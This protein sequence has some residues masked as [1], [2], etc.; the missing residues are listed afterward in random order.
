MTYASEQQA[1][2][3]RATCRGDSDRSLMSSDSFSIKSMEAEKRHLEE[4]ETLRIAGEAQEEEILQYALERS[5]ADLNGEEKGSNLH[6]HG[7]HLEE[8]EDVAVPR[9]LE[10]YLRPTSLRNMAPHSNE[11]TRSGTRSQS[12]ASTRSSLTGPGHP[13]LLSSEGLSPSTSVHKTTQV[14]DDP[15]DLFDLS[16]REEP[17]MRARASSLRNLLG[18]PN[19]TNSPGT[20]SLLVESGN[21][22]TT[23]PALDRSN[24]LHSRRPGAVG[25]D[26]PAPR[27]KAPRRQPSGPDDISKVKHVSTPAPREKPDHV[28]EAIAAH[29]TGTQ[30]GV[31]ITDTS[32]PQQQA[33]MSP[34]RSASCKEAAASV[35]SVSLRPHFPDDA[36]L[37]SALS[38]LSMTTKPRDVRLISE[39]RHRKGQQ[40]QIAINAPLAFERTEQTRSVWQLPPLSTNE[41]NA[42]DWPTPSEQQL[43]LPKSTDDLSEEEQLR[44]EE[45][46]RVSEDFMAAELSLDYGCS[47]DLSGAAEHLTE[48]E[49]R[50][51]Q[52]ALDRRTD[53]NG[54]PHLTTE[55]NKPTNGADQVS[56]EDLAAIASAVNDVEME[57]A[58]AH[59]LRA[60]DEEEERKSVELA[61]KLIREE[62]LQSTSESHASI[63]RHTQQGNVRTMTRG[64]YE[65]QQV[66]VQPLAGQLTADRPC[67]FDEDE[68]IAAGFRINSSGRQQW[69][70]RDQSSVI[71]PNNEVRTKHDTLLNGQANAERLG[72]ESEVVSTI[73]NQAFN[74]FLQSVQGRKCESFSKGG[75]RTG[76]DTRATTS[77]A[78]DTNVRGEITKAINNHLIEKCNGVVKEGK[79][80]VIYHANKGSESGGFDVAVKVFKRIQEFRGRGDYVDGDPRYGKTAFRSLSSREQLKV[81]AEKEYRNLIRA[82]RVGVP[83]PTPLSQQENI[84]FMRFLGTDGWPSPQLRD[85]ELRRGSSRWNTLY[86]Q[87]LNSIVR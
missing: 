10:R 75:G 24:S 72:L 19:S 22:S 17:A 38:N 50:D 42:S 36:A 7:L 31:N 30:Q 76:S 13:I 2:V 81:W 55:D 43:Q 27:V 37:N 18:P 67:H 46:L 29:V 53:D 73:G 56:E 69:S 20:L 83:V 49:L 47:F 41:S 35:G 4:L 3:D 5:L 33:T 71:G 68:F 86:S 6:V 14:E 85:L 79:E 74:S 25:V 52:Q 11:L 58:I 8:E 78:M 16:P 12:V 1:D 26:R 57:Q 64:E 84:V 51:I 87:V 28:R 61:I 59:A 32:T 77:G 40:Q 39:A 48:V 34:N 21:S 65:A 23:S 63:Q 66:K 70:R 15:L 62:Q 9:G 45:A 54:F 44:I 60:A 82:S 80:A